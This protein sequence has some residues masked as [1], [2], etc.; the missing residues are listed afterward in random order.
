MGMGLSCYFSVIYVVFQISMMRRQRKVFMLLV[1]WG[2]WL[3]DCIFLCIVGFIL[4]RVGLVV[5]VWGMVDLIV[6]Y[7][8]YQFV[9][10]VL[11]CFSVCC[12]CELVLVDGLCLVQW[13]NY[14]GCMDY[15]WF[16]YYML[17]V[18]LQGGY[19]IYFVDMFCE[20]GYLGCYCI[21][22]VEYELCW[23]V[24]GLLCFVYFYLLDWVWVDCVVCLLDVEFCVFMLEQ[25][26]FGCDV[27]LSVW[28]EG[29]VMCDWSDLVE[30]LCIDVFSQVVL[31]YFVLQVVRLWLCQ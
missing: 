4:V 8:V 9:F 31:D 10:D 14:G 21:L 26:I 3:C 27:V 24:V 12:E 25:C 22:F 15:Q 30:C 18:Y 7:I 19:D 6:V 23:N 13:C 1:W 29:V 5:L 11:G 16:G 17:L 28:V 20:I 2:W